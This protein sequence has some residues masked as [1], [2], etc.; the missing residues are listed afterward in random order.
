MHFPP[1]YTPYNREQDVNTAVFNMTIYATLSSIVSVRHVHVALRDFPCQNVRLI[2]LGFVGLQ[3]PKRLLYYTLSIHI[4]LLYTY[5]YCYNIIM[6]NVHTIVDKNI[7]RP[8][9]IENSKV[10]MQM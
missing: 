7:C 4:T 1:I 8:F 6:L 10:K 5:Y 9:Q 3:F 2:L